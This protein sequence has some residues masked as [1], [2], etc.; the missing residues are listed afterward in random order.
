VRDLQSRNGTKVNGVRVA[1]KK[2]L[3]PGDEVAFAKHKFEVVY[4]PESNGAEG[5][6]PPEETGV[7]DVMGRSLLDRAGLIRRKPGT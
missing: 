7:S 4:N 5:P 2:R 3:D 6:P 1:N